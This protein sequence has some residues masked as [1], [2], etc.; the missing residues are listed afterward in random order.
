MYQLFGGRRA[1]P[2]GE[3][4]GSQRASPQKG[5]GCVAPSLPYRHASR[6][7]PSRGRVAQTSAGQDTGSCESL[8]TNWNP[9]GLPGALLPGAMGQGLLHLFPRPARLWEAGRGQALLHH[10]LF[11]V[12]RGPEAQGFCLLAQQ[13]LAYR[14]LPPRAGAG[15]GGGA[16]R[17]GGKGQRS[18]AVGLQ[19][20]GDC[21]RW[22]LHLLLEPV[23][24][25]G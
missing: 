24:V 19:V 2:V 20:Q 25:L 3:E 4:R 21:S 15:F 16:E 12:R 14:F 17:G 8:C 7:R 11:Q 18:E 22:R 6:K 10:T 1:T 23:E 5:T 9:F 13:V